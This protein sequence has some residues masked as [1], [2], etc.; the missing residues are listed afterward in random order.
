MILVA[1]LLLAGVASTALSQT[2]TVTLSVPADTEL[3]EGEGNT[4]VTVTATLSAARTTDTVIDLTLGGTARASDYVEVS[5][6]DITISA[7]AVTGSANLTLRAVDDNF[8]EGDETVTIGG[9]ASGV[10]VDGV[11]VPI[12]D[13]EERP[14]LAL[15]VSPAGSTQEGVFYEEGQ[16][17]SI[18]ITLTLSGATFE[19][20]STFS[21]QLRPQNSNSLDDFDFDE[22]APPWSLEL[23]AGR[24][25]GRRRVSFTVVDD[26]EREGQEFAHF[27]AQGNVAGT[28]F[29]T[30][31]RR[32]IQIFASD[33]P[34]R[35]QI[36]CNAGYVEDSILCYPV[37]HGITTKTHSIKMDWENSDLVTPSSHTF[38]IP[39]QRTGSLE[40]VLNATFRFDASAADTRQEFDVTTS[41]VDNTL[42]L[43]RTG[44]AVIFDTARSDYQINEFLVAAWPGNH[45]VGDLAITLDFYDRSRFNRNRP[46][47][48]VGTGSVIVELDSGRVS[49]PCSG[50][51]DGIRC[52]YQV[53][54]GDF[55]FDGKI[56]VPA[57]AVQFTRWRDSRST[58]IT[59]QVASPLPAQARTFEAPGMRIYGGQYPI[60]LSVIPQT[61]Q[62][63]TGE[64][65]LTITASTLGVGWPEAIVLPLTF[66]D[67]STTADDYTVSGTPSITIPAGQREASTTVKFTPTDDLRR[68]SRREVVRIEG[69]KGAAMTPF[70]RGTDLTILD[71]SGIALSVSPSSVSEN[72]GAQQVM[73][74]ATWADTADTALTRDLEIALAWGGT[75]GSGDY[76]RTG[77]NTVTIPAN[78]R[79]GSATAT[80][81]PTDD[82][83]LEGAETIT[84]AGS[85]LGRTVAGTELT[86]T[87]DETLPAV[88]LAVDET[89][90][91]EGG[92]AEAIVV[93]ATLDPV[94]ANA[95]ADTTVTLRLGGTATAGTDYAA[96]WSPTSQEITI[97]VGTTSGSNTVT[98]TLTPTDDSIAEGDETVVV[99]GDAVTGGRSLVVEVATVTIDDDDEQGINFAPTSLTVGEGG[100]ATYEVWLGSAPTDDVTVTISSTDGTTASVD[101]EELTFTSSDWSTRQ[102]V[103]VTGEDDDYDNADDKREASIRHAAAGGGYDTVTEAV[104]PVTVTDDDEATSFSIADA[105]ATEGQTVSFTVTR[106]GA[107]G[108]TASVS[109]NTAEDEDGDHPAS[110]A[111]YTA[112]TTAQVLSFADGETTKSFT[113]ATTQDTLDEAD[114]TFLVELS[115]PGTGAS[116]RTGEGT[117]TGTIT[118]NDPAPS[119]SFGTVAAV[120]E[121][122]SGETANMTFTVEL[123]AASGRE[124]TVDYADTGS[125]SAT[126]GTDYAALTAGTL[127]FATGT[128]SQSF[129]VSVTGDDVDEDDETVTVRL[130][131]PAGA[132]FVGGV[133]TLDASGQITDDDTRGITVS[134]ASSG[135]TVA[136]A[137]YSGTSGTTENVATYTV[138]LESAPT[139]TVT[140]TVESADT[141]VATVSPASLEFTP[142]AWGAQTVSV[143]GQADDVDNA[144]DRRTTTI[145]HEVDGEDTDYEDETAGD[146][147]VTVTDDDATPAATLVL[148]PATIDESGATNS[149]TVTATLSGA[150]HAEVTVVVS[151]PDGSPVT[152]TTNKTLTIAA[153][154]TTSTGT[155]TLTAVDNNVDAPNATVTVSGDATGGGVA[156]P[157]DVELTIED[158]DDAPTGITLSAAPD[159]VGEEDGATTITVTAAVNG[160]TR[161][162]EAKTVTV[163]VDDDSATSPGDYAAVTDFDITIA[164]GA[165]SATGTF[166]LTPVNDV[167]DEADET[168]TVSGTSAGLTITGDEITIEDDDDAST[169]IT[170]SAA[171]DSVGEEDGAT[172]ITVT[173]AVNGSTRYAEAKTVT[174]SVDDDSATSPGDYAAVTDFDITIPAGAASATGTFDLTPVNDVL[175]EADETVTVSGTSG[176]LTITGDEIT[177][178]DNDDAPSFSIGDA[179]GDEGDA[180]TFTITRGGA[181]G[182]AVSVSWATAVLAGQATTADFT[183]VTA[184]AV[185]FASGDTT[186]EVT[187]QTTE[188]A[189]DE[190][191]ETFEVRLSNATGRAVIAADGGTATGTITDDEGTPTVTLVLDPATIN[192]NGGTTSSTVTATLSGESSAAVTVVVSSVGSAATLSAN[193]TLTIAVGATT[194]TGTV[195]LTAVDND[196]DAPNATVT[197]SGVASGGGVAN[198]TDQTLTITDDEG[199]PTVTL[200]LD[201]ATINENGGTTS[202][203]V[204]ATLSGESSAAVTVVVSSTGSAATLS[205]NKTLT[206][207]AGST[208]STGTV[209]LTAVDNDVDAPNATV[210]VSGVATGGGVAN[211]V[212]QTLT[213]TDDEGTPTVT[214]V[215]DPAT[216]SENGG[217][218]SSTVTATLSGESSSAVTVV[219]SSTGAAATLSA[220]KTLTIAAGATTSTGTVTLTAVDNDVDAPDATVTVS[221]VASGGG[222]ANPTDQTLTVT[223]DDGAPTATLVLDPATITESG[224]GNASTVTATLSHPSG[225]AVTIT[226]SV[227]GSA[228]VALSANKALTFAAGD[229]TSSGT[230]TLTAVDNDDDAVDATVA[231]S[232]AASGGGVANPA[233]VTL[234]ITDD[235]DP[236]TATLV[237]TPTSI[238]ESGDGNAST[239]TATL[240]G[241]ARAAV[242]LTVASAPG[243][244]TVAADFTQSGTT[245][246]FAVGETASSG[247]VTITAVDNDVHEANKSVTI[248]ASASGGG[249]VSNPATQTLTI[250]EDDPATTGATLSVAPA[251][252]SEDAG[253][254]EIEVTATVE[255]AAR[256]A[257]TVIT[258]SVAPDTA[259]AADFEAVTDFTLTIAAG[260]TSG[261]ATFTLT[262]VNDLI[263]DG[264]ETIE[265]SGTTTVSGYTVSSA[266][267]T[268][269]NYDPPAS[270]VNLELDPASVAEDAGATEVEVTARFGAGFRGEDTDVMISVGADTASSAD[271]AAVSDFTVTIAAGEDAATGTFTLTPVDDAI[272]EGSETIAITG[273]TTVADL[274][275]GSVSLTLADD[276]A[277]P[278]VTLTL[279]PASIDES[280]ASNASTVTAGLSGVSSAAVTVVVSS[281]GSAATLSANRTL[282]IA[283][284][285]TTSTGTV[286][287]TAVDNDVDAPDATVVVSGE[288][289]GGGV[290][291]PADVTLTITDDEDAPE[292]ITLTAAPDTVTEDAGATEVTVTAAVEGTNRFADE[293]VVTVSVVGGTAISA[294]DYAA[295]ANFD[296]TIA[297]GAGSGTGTF[298]LTPVDDT[299]VEGAETIEVT[300]SA[301]DL[302]VTSDEIT[303]VDDEIA[304]EDREYSFEMPEG[305]AGPM[306][307][308]NVREA[309]DPEP[310]SFVVIEGD[311]RRFDVGLASGLI[312]YIGGGEDYESGRRHFEMD[313]EVTNGPQ[314]VIAMAQVGVRVMNVP[315]PP[316]P[317]DDEA[318]TPEDVPV[319][320]RVLANDADPDGDAL[321][322]TAVSRPG[323]GSTTVVGDGIRYT[324][325]LNWYGT[326]DFTY[327][328]S[329]PGGFTGTAEVTVVVTPVND[330]PEARDD[331][332]ETFEDQPVRVEVLANDTDVD[333]DRMKLVAVGPAENG[334]TAMNGDDT[335]LYTP[336]PDWHGT[337]RFTYRIADP[338]GLE[339]AATVVVTVWP[340]N[341]P[342][343][344]IGTIPDRRVEEGGEPGSVD[345]TPYFG[346]VDDA[347]LS[348]EAVS[349]NENA[350]R[351]SVTGATLSIIPVVTGE[352]RITVTARDAE[353]LTAT[354]S[355]AVSVGDELVRGLMTDVFAGFGR[356]SLSSL[357]STLG[358]R[359]ETE[360]GGGNRFTVAGQYL[361]SMG[362]F[363]RIGMGGIQQTQEM[364]FGAA[365]WEQARQRAAFGG[366][367]TEPEMRLSSERQTN[368]PGFGFGSSGGGEE[369]RWLQSTD[370]LFSF[371]GEE[372]EGPGRRWT[373]WGQGDIQTFRGEPEEASS[374]EGDLRTAYLGLD[375]EIG[376]TWLF[377]VG[378]SHSTGDANWRVGGSSGALDTRLTTVHPYLRWSDGDT[379]VWALGGFGEGEAEGERELT[380]LREE[381]PLRLGLG[382]VEGRRRLG[383]TRFGLG[384]DVR[385]EASWARLA[386]GAGEETLDG[387]TAVARRLRTGLEFDMRWKGP[388][389]LEIAPFAAASTLHDGG[390]GPEGFGLEVAGG[391]RLNGERLRLEAQGRRLALH[392]EDD[393][394]EQGFS[395]N[396][397]FGGGRSRPGWNGSLRQRWGAS[398]VGADT[399]WQ[400]HFAPQSRSL[401]EGFGSASDGAS[402]GMDAE[403][404]YGFLV[405]ESKLLGAFGGYGRLGDGRRVEIGM[406]L[407]GIGLFGFGADNPALVEFAGERY[408]GGGFGADYRMR[409]YGVIRFGGAA[410]AA[411]EPGTPCPANGG[412]SDW[413]RDRTN[414][415]PAGQSAPPDSKPSP[416]S[417][418]GGGSIGP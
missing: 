132:A 197:V 391:L 399:L 176:T 122:A 294:D 210:T 28:S 3:E 75:A 260:E 110:T 80:I 184:T 147:T 236:P 120:T 70:V 395:L 380:G 368:G 390:D 216:I 234:T 227:P 375:L 267:I 243:E 282:T 18:D 402:D 203:T 316:E 195:T 39:A 253:A 326:D 318:E 317:G 374:Y 187:V 60:D 328:V 219:V 154:S 322:I 91:S 92:E 180:I 128:T 235:D 44:V 305:Q 194:S 109:W 386:T 223:D 400:D 1:A 38:Q 254:T 183:A 329:D 308:G 370:L 51:S 325:D 285:A 133:T 27:R 182:N 417:G 224:S 341:D 289:S 200:V 119:L 344:A 71:A 127:T 189:I 320:I 175:D 26:A 397:S 292:G 371:G 314:G 265:V 324:P 247:S 146:V 215:L 177:I 377:G 418:S 333:G 221:G 415:T 131:S 355:F 181:T 284:G 111:D 137:D 362:N 63:G 357:R 15:R 116:I 301:G 121:G 10:T 286:T 410:P 269:D 145:T 148:D 130:S 304:I 150:S 185:S 95:N 381:S 76:A 359:L 174:V 158:D 350:V 394:R 157:D 255:G 52:D 339:D 379:S 388:A 188:D 59:G 156:D 163:S 25:S 40:D 106:S 112:R 364:A 89:S 349:S 86:L 45:R 259:Q 414:L 126:S 303:L 134:A 20:D 363:G 345:L 393:Y 358:R 354:Q 233:D 396:A 229:T 309:A 97:P 373:I 196:V 117:A 103:T 141:D 85:T 47:E 311:S 287:L 207:A 275:V 218:T 407:G 281:T 346:D 264:G 170:L 276:E 360:G 67:I 24:V 190:P 378:A 361:S 209:M 336:N 101:E 17:G 79:S 61:V 312:F 306:I 412:V 108:G 192:E 356:A 416:Y 152:V 335:V 238:A 155:V 404:G 323:N 19:T 88:Q 62:E 56:V 198:P 251:S 313:V 135:L 384:V 208:T 6:P 32:G 29:T 273:T 242:T 288:A 99:E 293:R 16:S 270:I 231:V 366:A 212:D 413:R 164:A 87:D 105:S 387:L 22:D 82:N 142:T 262:P 248:S 34:L 298:T 367:L 138:A 319:L 9:T 83:L 383:V 246:T 90:V 206:I 41:P 258:I 217:T 78:A 408:D 115:A 202:S 337:D 172:T 230:V 31:N 169:G 43:R 143:T 30:I 35:I 93:S 343:Y 411:C 12:E 4:T 245:L 244:D 48:P 250:E 213:V 66:A 302:T 129:T 278:T 214:L 241:P 334:H 72:G 107:T 123:S 232:G 53:Q 321:E 57:G 372:E 332:A 11:N 382:L 69:S 68:E 100:T 113:V 310:L 291:D 46:V 36:A 352:A 165:A 266:T 77:G 257:E 263:A 7:G 186:K 21:I 315:E 228:P 398:G 327:T 98:L 277:A 153:G 274:S 405:G 295:V 161:Y 191:N 237:L 74:T 261:T 178:E 37:I 331:E 409:L 94:V 171:P 369:G 58:E 392:A 5:L 279:D 342:P 151:V 173:A 96:A 385:T 104:L 296:I 252:V 205:A 240:D 365:S 401:D 283:A 297:A 2:P 14:T 65:T 338:E 73:V 256:S 211:P 168:V 351:V 239:V 149:S 42:E 139:G 220:N 54:P 167:L 353:G 125:G 179:S 403:M 340:V 268:L 166:D 201:P 136:E 193:K 144:S 299:V 50:G 140:I 114:E 249:G 81:T 84:I 118:D 280:G 13:N 347:V 33:Q 406:N 226:V 330:P 389:G 160:S 199:T 49:L 272:H 204:T 290:E 307:V 271:F 222:V 55:D 159:S 300:G 225:V 124:V 23:G 348:Y 8:F 376:G 162:V 64:Q 102:T